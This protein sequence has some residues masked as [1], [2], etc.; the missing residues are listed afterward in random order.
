MPFIRG[1][2]RQALEHLHVEG[3]VIDEIAL[4]FTEACARWWTR[5]TSGASPTAGT[6]SRWRSG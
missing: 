6:G 4:A 1:L 2:Y 5:W 3:T